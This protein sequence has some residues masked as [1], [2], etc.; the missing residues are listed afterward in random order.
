MS[1]IYIMLS[2]RWNIIS[3]F[4]L[5]YLHLQIVGIIIKPSENVYFLWHKKIVLDIVILVLTTTLV[6]ISSE[7]KE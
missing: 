1:H 5:Q 3:I 6:A 4:H 7:Q 2:F